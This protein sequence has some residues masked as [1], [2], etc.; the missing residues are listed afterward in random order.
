MTE[1][2]ETPILRIDELRLTLA[3]GRYSNRPREVLRGLS[4]EIPR[5]SSVAL[6]G[7]SGSGKTL[8]C[9]A[10]TRFFHG[11]P[12]REVRGSVWFENRNLLAT[13]QS[14]LF[15]IRG[16]RIGHLLQNA[17]EH[18]HPRLTIAQH[19]DLFLRQK[20]RK[21][22]DRTAHAMRYLYR[23]GMVDP[24]ALLLDRVFPVELD[25]MTRQKIMIALVLACEPDLLVADEPTAEF[26]SHSVTRIVDAL[27]SL[28]RERGLSILFA[29]GRLRR[30][31]QFGDVVAVLDE[32]VIAECGSARDLFREP[33]QD[34]T[35]AFLDGTIIAG[36][37]KDRL[38]PQHG[39]FSKR[40]KVKGER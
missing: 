7:T 31:E 34:I 30:A 6:L 26:D 39:C 8:L 12:V 37:P 29:T 19:F 21:I 16:S 25:V 14:R 24:D 18:F 11:L 13:G 10:V 38:L 9:R 1:K 23:V 4:L 27:E 17:H 33:K 20:R 5:G 28:K 2:A 22:A 32:G 40:E 15:Q 36:K 35:K 3:P